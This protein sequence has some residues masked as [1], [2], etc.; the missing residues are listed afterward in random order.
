MGRTIEQKAYLGDYNEGYLLD[1]LQKS[2]NGP[3][4]FSLI[5]N[6][7]IL[8]EKIGMLTNMNIYTAVLGNNPSLS[9]LSVRDF[10]G[11]LKFGIND[12]YGNCI[13]VLTGTQ[14]SFE[15]IEEILGDVFA[16]GNGLIDIDTK[17]WKNVNEICV[18]EK[19]LFSNIGI[20]KKN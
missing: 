13:I 7:T 4:N 12:G 8:S 18:Y 11:N 1:R 16:L 2:Y 14:P 15:F 17:F 5:E 20:I 19:Y 9:L 6:L 3:F 10:M